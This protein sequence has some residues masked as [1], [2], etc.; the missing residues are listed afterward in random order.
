MQILFDDKENEEAILKILQEKV[1]N[2]EPRKA[3][4]PIWKAGGLWITLYVL[5]AFIV[6]LK[7]FPALFRMFLFPSCAIRF[8]FWSTWFPRKHLLP[9]NWFVFCFAVQDVHFF[10]AYSL[11][12]E[13]ALSFMKRKSYKIRPRVRTFEASCEGVFIL[14][15]LKADFLRVDR[16]HKRELVNANVFPIFFC[17]RGLM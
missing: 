2:L 10:C 3:K 16:Q 4:H 5:L 17:E 8:S 7:F 12:L 6:L 11:I 14:T 1:R 15:V 9:G 13:A